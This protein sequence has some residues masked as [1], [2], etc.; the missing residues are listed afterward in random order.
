MTGSPSNP[1]RFIRLLWAAHG[2]G[3]G[4]WFEGKGPGY[5]P[6]AKAKAKAWSHEPRSED[7]LT[8]RMKHV[9]SHFESLRLTD[10]RN[11]TPADLVWHRNEDPFTE[12]ECACHILAT[13]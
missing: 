5:G 10:T 7:R 8:A 6:Y 2:R 13:A 12:H 3:L 1:G 11:K 9:C 4:Q